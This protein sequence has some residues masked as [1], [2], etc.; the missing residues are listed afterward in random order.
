ML[1]GAQNSSAYQM[2]E[3]MSLARKMLPRPAKVISIKANVYIGK[4]N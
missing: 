2:P 1:G 3:G 4:V